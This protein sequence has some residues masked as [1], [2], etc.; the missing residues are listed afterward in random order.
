MK[1][2]IQ[3]SDA[4]GFNAPRI[5]SLPSPP[6]LLTESLQIGLLPH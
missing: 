5:G 4:A 2:M 1:S 6:L 3:E